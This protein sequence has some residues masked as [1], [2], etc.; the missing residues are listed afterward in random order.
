MKTITGIISCSLIFAVISAATAAEFIIREYPDR[1][2]VEYDGSSDA[3]QAAIPQVNAPKP[4]LSTS[5]IRA[6]RPAP[7]TTQAS[8]SKPATAATQSSEAELE[9]LL[10]A[11]EESKSKGKPLAESDGTDASTLAYS[12][13]MI[14]APMPASPITQT[15]APMQSSSIIQASTSAAAPSIFQTSTPVAPTPA[16][17]PPPSIIQDSTSEPASS[18]SQASLAEQEQQIN[19]AI[20]NAIKSRLEEEGSK[21][22]ISRM[23]S[24]MKRIEMLKALNQKA[25]E[26]KKSAMK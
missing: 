1:F 2:V 5:R 7:A 25:T 20:N 10:Q 11:N 8:T 19:N 18:I 16:M 13:T 9:Q 12:V 22:V 15:S 24:W 6:P 26:A 21:R 4:A 14:S 17:T 3:E 23:E